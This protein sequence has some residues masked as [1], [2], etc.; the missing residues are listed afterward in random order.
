[1]ADYESADLR[2]LFF[3][4]VQHAEEQQA[5]NPGDRPP[6]V[7]AMLKWAR[8]T[9]EALEEGKTQNAFWASQAQFVTMKLNQAGIKQRDEEHDRGLTLWERL[10]LYECRSAMMQDKIL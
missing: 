9:I 1:M 6:E 8:D 2:E 10:R 4:T 3:T 5:E 7:Y